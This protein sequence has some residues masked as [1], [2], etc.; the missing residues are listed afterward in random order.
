VPYKDK[1]GR[2]IFYYNKVSRVS[3]FEMPP[4]YVR[5]KTYV[6]KEATFGLSFYH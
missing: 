5:D 2:G 6:M 4:D 1:R 3:Q